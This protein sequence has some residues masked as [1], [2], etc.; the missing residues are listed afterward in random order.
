MKG[1]DAIVSAINGARNPNQDTLLETTAEAGV[2]RFLPIHFAFDTQRE[3]FAEVA[4]VTPLKE[5][6]ID[7]LKALEKK[8]MSWTAVITGSWVGFVS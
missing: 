6:P 7:R 8:G 4:P 5:G 3:G 1:Q 2:R